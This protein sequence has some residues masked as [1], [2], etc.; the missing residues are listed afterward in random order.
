[1]SIQLRPYQ[2]EAIV[3]ARELIESGFRRIGLCAPCAAGKT[4]T[5]SALAQ[6]AQALG[7]RTMVV[8]HR[9]EL[10]AQGYRKLIEAGLSHDDTGVILSGVRSVPA[11]GEQWGEDDNDAWKNARRRPSAPVQIG[12]IQT[13]RARGYLV[14][15][16]PP[17]L[18]IVDEAH[19]SACSSYEKLFE[20]YPDAN[21]IGFS[22][23]WCRADGKRLPFDKLVTIAQPSELREMGFLVPNRIFSAKV[24]SLPKLD[25]V[26]LK[27]GDYDERELA[28][29][30]NQTTLIGDAVAHWKQRADGLRTLVFAVD[31]EHMRAIAAR[32]QAA[33]IQ[34]A[35]V[36]GE[37]PNAERDATVKKLQRGEILVLCSVGVFTEGTDIPE[38]ECVI[39]M[40]PTKSLALW[41]QTAGRGGRICPWTGKKE[42]II[43]D[44]AGNAQP[45]SMGGLG[46]PDADRPWSLDVPKKRRRS[47][48]QE[49]TAKMCPNPDC[50]EVLEL[51]VTVCPKCG[52]ELPTRERSAPQEVDGE[53]VE[54]VEDQ[55]PVN[56]RVLEGWEALVAEWRAENEKR[57]ATPTGRPRKAGWL[58]HEWKNR[59]HFDVPRGA[60]MPKNTPE[61]LARIAELDEKA[62]PA[63]GPLDVT[64]GAPDADG[65]STGTVKAA[66]PAAPAMR[67]VAW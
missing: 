45:E 65:W 59:N 41:I 31:R 28:K 5:F 4:V 44:H 8:A 17:G 12:S 14:M 53:L 38:I 22:A 49:D 43:L 62:K 56:T 50:L 61:E 48:S 23:T 42:C 40:R 60:K 27:G 33:D 39:H 46:R 67:R 57:M 52:T 7:N 1:M 37:T 10:I 13:I 20:T 51:G 3:K 36:D 21:V 26:K 11:R 63:T 55:R 24:D 19:L 58:R 2:A 16:P 9:R 66:A 30:C 54:L 64:W 25:G 18:I 6:M 29:A 15:N 35:C 32:F 47:A 34:A